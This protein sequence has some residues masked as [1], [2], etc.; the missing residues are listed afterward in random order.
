MTTLPKARRGV[1]CLGLGSITV[2]KPRSKPVSIAYGSI[3]G[4]VYRL[5]ERVL[6]LAEQWKSPIDTDADLR[7]LS[8]RCELEITLLAR[9][10]LTD[11][12]WVLN[13]LERARELRIERE[14]TKPLFCW[15]DTFPTSVFPLDPKWG[16]SFRRYTPYNSTEPSAPFPKAVEAATHWWRSRKA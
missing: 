13:R 5:R 12:Q 9:W 14:K 4:P 8:T 16:R 6:Q 15:V 11:D 10:A 1:S 7:H 3:S 2:K